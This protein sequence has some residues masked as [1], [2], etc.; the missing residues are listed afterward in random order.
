M[1]QEQG[2]QE[3]AGMAQKSVDTMMDIQKGFL[4]ALQELNQQWISGVN[5]EAA[6]ASEFLTKL[7]TAKSIPDAAVACQGCMSRQM[8]IMAENSRQFMAA[9]ERLMPHLFGNDKSSTRT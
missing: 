8:E 2:S 4:D 1:A 5:A 6:L 7:T 9:G 3:F